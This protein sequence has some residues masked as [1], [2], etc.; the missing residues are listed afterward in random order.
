MSDL[1]NRNFVDFTGGLNYTDPELNMRENYFVTAK[2]VELVYD[3]TI[4][5][6]NGFRL[7]KNLYSLM[8]PDEAINEIFYFQLH[9]LVCTTAGR[10]ITIADDNTTEVIW[11]ND[12][13]AA[14]TTP[15]SAETNHVWNY[16]EERIFGTAC[17]SAA[18]GNKFFLSNGFDKPLEVNLY[19]EVEGSAKC[20][21]LVGSNDGIVPIFYKCQMVNHYC[22][23]VILG[24]NKVYVSEKN[25]PLGW[26]NET[27]TGDSTD[28]G[29]VVIPI[30]TIVGL[31]NEN[32]VDLAAYKNMLCIITDYHIILLELDTYTESTTW[33]DVSG[34]NIT[35]RNHTPTVNMVVDNAGC[36]TV[37]SVQ[38]TMKTIVFLSVNGINNLERNAIS[39]N[40]VPVS[41]SEKI[42]PYIKHK[43]TSE[44]FSTGVWSF[45]DRQKYMYGIKF[46]DDELLCLSFHPNISD[47]CYWIWNNIKYKSFTNNV[48]G[49]VLAA[50]DYGVFIYT[51]DSSGYC[52]DDTIDTD[53]TVK[54]TNFKMEIETPWTSFGKPNNVKTM[55]YINV[56]TD[57][58]ARFTTKT[59]CDLVD[60]WQLSIDMLGGS[61]QG[62]GSGENPYFGG[63]LISGSE[64]L[65][66]YPQ[67]FMYAKF[68]FTSEDDKPLRIIRYG[69]FYRI[70]GIRR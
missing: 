41:L 60:D 37:G 20:H 43:L 15:G 36:A 66:E 4:K 30:D 55:E 39:Q 49:R 8:D 18:N 31:P 13:A 29:A 58:T 25:N 11:D 21:Y 27:Q 69:S 23:A 67:V 64:E 32:I 6:R 44:V 54:T 34:S 61:K 1:I 56:I 45:V 19:P 52:K 7:V 70:G 16:P 38:S 28:L 51:D 5:K 26:T 10:I 47:P 62:F 40:F 46:G 33:N 63:G 57:G 9:V 14:G 24:S 50:D 42:L 65:V 3:S 53:G 2:N 22:C 48:H 68:G 35:K 59:T 12:I 17:G